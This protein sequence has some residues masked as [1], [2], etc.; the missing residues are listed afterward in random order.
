MSGLEVLEATLITAILYL[1]SLSLLRFLIT[2][3]GIDTLSEIPKFPDL[4][5]IRVSFVSILFGIDCEMRLT[6][7][8]VK[9]RSV[10]LTFKPLS[11]TSPTISIAD[12]NLAVEISNPL[13]LFN[14]V[15]R[16]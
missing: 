5:D 4:R 15:R 7:S 8:D 10:I 12:T 9:I 3:L 13:F 6:R 14:H 1:N 16:L 11:E 2:V